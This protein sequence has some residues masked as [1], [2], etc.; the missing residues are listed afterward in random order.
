MYV[1]S[2]DDN[3]YCLNASSGLSL[4][5]YSTQGHISASPAVSEGIVYIAAWDD[6]VYALG[7]QSTNESSS[8]T[9]TWLIGAVAAIAVV[10]VVAVLLVVMRKKPKVKKAKR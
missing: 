4:W 7:M 1:G 6:N 2:W 8:G 9:P 3:I 10:A 5:T